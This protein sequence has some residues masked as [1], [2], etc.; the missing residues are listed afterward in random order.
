MKKIVVEIND[1]GGAVEGEDL[2]PMDLFK[3]VL[4]LVSMLESTTDITVA[5]VCDGVLE[6]LDGVKATSIKVK[7]RKK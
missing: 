2:K 6:T 3:A 7:R 1:E 4:V 5:E